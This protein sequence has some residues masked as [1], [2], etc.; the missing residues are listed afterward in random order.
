MDNSSTNGL[1]DKI[2]QLVISGAVIGL[3]SACTSETAVMSSTLSPPAESARP[4]TPSHPVVGSVG[5]GACEKTDGKTRGEVIK[6]FPVAGGEN[7]KI[8]ARGG[9]LQVWRSTRCRTVWVKLVK[10]PKYTR[11]ALEGSVSLD[12][13]TMASPA[14]HKFVDTTTRGSIETPAVGL[15]AHATF[16]VHGGFLGLYQFGGGGKVRL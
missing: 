7:G 12:V 9:T 1:I 8:Y 11:K 6:L 5:G 10:L 15:G 14:V 3:A 2:S 16:E 4:S 13:P